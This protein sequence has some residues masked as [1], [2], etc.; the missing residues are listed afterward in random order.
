MFGGGAAGAYP[1]GL[2]IPADRLA[3]ANWAGAGL[4]TKGG[5]SGAGIPVRNTIFATLSPLGGATVTISIASP[6]IVTW[7]AHGLSAGTPF[8]FQNSGG[9]LP[10]PLTPGALY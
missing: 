9:Y 1:T 5:P 6:G 3:L 4:Q 10:T 2:A 7:T 8:I